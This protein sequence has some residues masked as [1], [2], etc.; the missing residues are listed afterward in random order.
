MASRNVSE[1]VRRRISTDQPERPA[2]S[3]RSVYWAAGFTTGCGCAKSAT[4]RARGVFI[5]FGRQPRPGRLKSTPIPLSVAVAHQSAA[6][7]GDIT[8][9]STTATNR[10]QLDNTVNQR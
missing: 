10:P 1:V 8:I 4:N 9:T 2:L 5:L 3:T 6:A 7:F